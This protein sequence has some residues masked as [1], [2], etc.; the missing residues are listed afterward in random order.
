MD[1]SEVWPLPH[2]AAEPII[3]SLYHDVVGHG[4]TL[5]EAS[6]NLLSPAHTDIE[7]CRV[8]NHGEARAKK[9]LQLKAD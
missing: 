8:D 7:A 3:S 2:K 6:P 9:N 1:D 5:D 4:I